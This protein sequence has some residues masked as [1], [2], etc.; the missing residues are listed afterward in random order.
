MSKFLSIEA[1]K[2]SFDISSIGVLTYFGLYPVYMF[3][4]VG[5]IRLLSVGGIPLLLIFLIIEII[6][7][8]RAKKAIQASIDEYKPFF[9]VYLHIL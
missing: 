6:S 2:N 5:Y 9:M 1:H 3:S 7:I 8:K 4:E